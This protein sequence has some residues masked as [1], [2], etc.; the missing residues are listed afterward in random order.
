MLLRYRRAARR[1]KTT[2][3]AMLI[4]AVTGIM[5]SAAAWS[6]NEEERR[7]ALLAYYLLG[8]PYILWDNI[9][10]GT[11]I[12]CAHIEKS[13]TATFY[14]DRKLG[15]SETVNTAASAIHLFTGNNIRAKGDLA[16][17]SL[18]IRLDVDRA[19]P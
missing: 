7:K 16:S 9:A 5:P 3:L 6:T 2:V 18:H 12:S 17:R 19:D 15:V 14:A 1:G 11:Q 13:C 8:V 4:M 10:R